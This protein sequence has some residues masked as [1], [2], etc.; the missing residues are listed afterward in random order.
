MSPALIQTDLHMPTLTLNALDPYV[1]SAAK[2]WNARRAQHLFLRMGHGASLSEI[3]AAL[4]QSPA[5]LVDTLVD[6][7]LNMPA[8]APPFWATWTWATYNGDISLYMSHQEELI[9]RWVRE[10]GDATHHLRSKLAMFWHNHFVVEYDV[11]RCP[12]YMWAYYN[13]LHTNCMGNFRLLAEQMGK[14]PAMLNY[15]NGDLNVAGEPNENYAREL[16]EL[17]TMG[18][19]NGYTQVDIPEVARALTGWMQDSAACEM[20]HFEPSLHDAGLKTIFGQTGHWNYDD[21]HEL[22]FTLRQDEVA[23]HICTKIYR[24]FVY[25]EVDDAVISEMAAIF[26]VNNWELAPVFRALF[27]SG[28]FFEEKFINAKIK[29]PLECF[30]SLL[31]QSGMVYNTNYDTEMTAFLAYYCGEM[32]QRVF[33]PVDVA[34]W[35]G[36]RSWLNENTLT[37]RWTHMQ[38]VLFYFFVINDNALEKLRQ[39]AISLT[40]NSKNPAVVTEA[41]VDHF[42]N[43][44]IAPENMATAVQYFK[45]DIPENYFT[46][47]IWNLNFTEAPYQILNLLFYLV[48]LPE[49]QLS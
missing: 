40:N 20:P 48:K 28:H 29:S 33:N 8:P 7:V 6:S 38:T 43:D 37:L 4:L 12:S 27:K 31:R 22:I 5:I 14:N 23:Q 32:G 44:S 24:H 41:L 39:I 3:Q 19:N 30:V 21:V 26:K 49:W 42:V 10:M 2:P 16:M 17:F 1:P 35:P 36:Q 15:L 45:G 11:F 25:D 34:G 47:G 9:R 13:L 46:N 18:E